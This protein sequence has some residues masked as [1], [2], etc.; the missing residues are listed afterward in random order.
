MNL[1][2]YYDNNGYLVGVS[3]GDITNNSQD[4]P[5]EKEGHF[6]TIYRLLWDAPERIGYHTH[7][8]EITSPYSGDAYDYDFESI[9]AEELSR[10]EL[11]KMF[12]DQLLGSV[13][14]V[15]PPVAKQGYHLVPMLNG[16]TIVWEFEQDPTP[17]TP[18]ADSGTYLNPI[19]Y[20][21][22]RTVQTGL[23]YTD[24]SDIWEAIDTGIPADFSDTT[25]FDI[26][27]DI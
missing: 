3:A 9:P 16:T 20:V 25:Y 8:K 11:L 15:T 24:G 6:N 22:G 4:I 23:W 14:I 19:T 17:S 5:M 12:H 21:P 7:L 2:K 18:V 10:D 13:T 27:S 1:K 26:I